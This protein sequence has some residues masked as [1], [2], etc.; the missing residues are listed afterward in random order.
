M[1]KRYK[2]TLPTKELA[3]ALG[4]K[5]EG[6]SIRTQLWLMGVASGVSYCRSGATFN[7]TFTKLDMFYVDCNSQ[8]IM[9]RVED[10]LSS[11]GCKI[12]EVEGV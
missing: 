8:C 5:F 1:L 2:I 12:E 11:Y 10:H 4:I 9:Q 6:Q 7:V 3:S